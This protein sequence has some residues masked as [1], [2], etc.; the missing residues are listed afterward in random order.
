[1][2]GFVEVAPDVRLWVEDVGR[3]DASALLLIMGRA[4]S[5]LYW[6]DALVESLARHHR[7]IRYDHRDTGRSTWAFDQHPY[8]IAD[9]ADDVLVILDD[10]GIERAHVVGV[11]MGGMLAQ[12]LLL[13]HPH[14]LLSATVFAT[15]ALGTV[16]G[17]AR[18][19]SGPDLP[20]PDRRLLALWDRMEKEG[21]RD[22]EAE[23]ERRVEEWRLLN[24]DVIEFDAE[25]FRRVE[26]RLIDHSGRLD[27]TTAHDRADRGGLDRGPSSPA[28]PFPPWSSRHRRTRSSRHR[29]PGTSPDRSATPGWSPSRV[30]ATP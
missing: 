26:E 24:G 28:C 10:L 2:E 11:S 27:T 21:P 22:R 30:W 23:I 19:R 1:M 25:E 5:G 7:V 17:P 29:T 20:G 4:S 3:A 6:P 12:L 16:P 13:D 9:L 14:R 15:S 8:A 18:P